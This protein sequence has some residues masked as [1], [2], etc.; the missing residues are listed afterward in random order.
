MLARRAVLN[1]V[2][3]YPSEERAVVY[4]T[5]V[6]SEV[7]ELCDRAGI[8]YR[9]RMVA[10]DTVAALSA[11]GGEKGLEETFFQ[12]VRRSDLLANEAVAS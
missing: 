6:M 7:E 1:F 5:H 12:L 2:K 8:I 9:G 3:A 10:D 4:S 11:Q